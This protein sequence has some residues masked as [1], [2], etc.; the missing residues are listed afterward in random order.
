MKISINILCWN[1]RRTLV[2]ALKV[3]KAELEGLDYEIIV[4]DNGSVDGTVDEDFTGVTYIRNEQN[5]GISH[6]KNQGIE[7]SRGE[8]IMLL[9]G[10]II[11][12]PGSILRLLEFLEETTDADAIGF[13]SN[14]FSSQ[15]NKNG[16]IHH[17]ER[18]D[19]LFQPKPHTS[20]CI[21]YG[22]YRRL[23]FEKVMFCVEG[24]FGEPGYGWEDFDF[25]SQM[26]RAGF[27]QWVAHIN[28]A[29]GKY[30]HDINSSIRAMGRQK[31]RETSVARRA[32]FYEREKLADAG[33]ADT[34]PS[35]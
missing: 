7:I 9:D 22:M 27:I 30:F 23:I 15:I 16:Q 33:Q 4:V 24:A 35:G 13:Y 17:E 5:R 8:Y 25:H 14:K 12:V 31:F 20:H 19:S 26:V 6:G 21:Y 29:G 11:P 10:D 18:C 3:I 32:V 1:T 28:H 2:Q 34:C